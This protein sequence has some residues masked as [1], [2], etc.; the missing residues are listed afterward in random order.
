MI[1]VRKIWL[2]TLPLSLYLISCSEIQKKE[3]VPGIEVTL[4][5]Q[6]DAKAFSHAIRSEFDRLREDEALS[7]LLTDLDTIES[8]YRKNQFE[9]QWIKQVEFS[10]SLTAAIAYLNRADDHAFDPEA[11]HR[12]TIVKSIMSSLN[13]CVKHSKLD[14]QAL[15]R[16]E[17]L[18]SEAIARYAQHVQIGV[19]NP[20]RLYG[21]SYKTPYDS[22]VDYFAPF[23]QR[24]VRTFLAAIQPKQPMY[25]ALQYAYKEE[26][27]K[28]GKEEHQPIKLKVKKIEPG[29]TSDILN[30]IA[31]RLIQLG[32]MDET[33]EDFKTYDS[34]LITGVVNFQQRNHLYPDG[35]IGKRTVAVMNITPEER[36][37][38]I[39]L[40][41]ERMRW[42]GYPDTSAYVL[43]NIA[44]F[45]LMVFDGDTVV[46]AMKTCVGHRSTQT[47]VLNGELAYMVLNP[48]W[49][50]P[51]SIARNE[52]IHKIKK[53]PNYLKK[54]N[55]NVYKNGKRVKGSDVKWENY[56]AG[57]LPFR[58]TQRPGY[59]N[60]LGR[61]KFIFPNK[62][63][64]YLH[65]TP[66]RYA[67]KNDM[68]AVSHGCV[69]VQEPVE[70]ARYLADYTDIT[71]EH[72]ELIGKRG[73]SIRV[74]FNH[75]IPVYL[76]Y[77][78]AWVDENGALQISNDVYKKD[79]TLRVALRTH[80]VID[81]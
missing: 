44:G 61:V 29:D 72:R 11:Y 1:S 76:D 58:F 18:T 8:W 34:T 59:G 6:F 3:E 80:R 41:L 47:P 70:L 20:K 49:S 39:K 26:L 22:V 15:A 71:D 14:Y 13:H 2:L 5:S 53:D 35:I 66:S 27:R 25:R 40:N 79:D 67:F 54:H 64:I 63:N 73:K 55:Y 32:D 60:A 75:K 9:P 50:V 43:V 38:L 37:E 36:V 74:D 42:H 56:S 81:L 65:D 52:M 17:I 57:N 21:S 33:A 31:T 68:R 46:K 28:V 7:P 10:E 23:N 78:T 62:S 12:S 19:E 24:D 4:R 45:R 16:T 30:L 77:F 48:T 51:K 69:R